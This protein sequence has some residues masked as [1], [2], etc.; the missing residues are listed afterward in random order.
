MGAK[1]LAV[2]LSRLKPQPSVPTVATGPYIREGFGWPCPGHL[3]P[4]RADRLRR[5][6]S[7]VRRP[8]PAPPPRQDHRR[9]T[10]ATTSKPAPS[11][12][13]W[14]NVPPGY[15]GLGFPDPSAWL[16]KQAP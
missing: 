8:H 4:G 6:P 13:G 15:I 5:T 16:L 3:A 11:P 9:S 1:A 7:A 10:T 14:P 2:A 12:R